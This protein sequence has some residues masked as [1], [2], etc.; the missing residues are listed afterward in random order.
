MGSTAGGLAILVGAAGLF[1]GWNARSARGA[2]SDLKLYKS[3][4]PGARQARTRTGLRSLVMIVL[5]LLVLS[6][7]VR[8]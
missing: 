7:L 4:I 8:G 6:I 5:T 1:I 2:H 3:R